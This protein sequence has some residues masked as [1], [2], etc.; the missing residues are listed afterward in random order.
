MDIGGLKMGK[1]MTK[2]NPTK[3]IVLFTIPMLLGNIFQQLYSMA[4][5]LIVSQTIG[6]DALAAVGSTGSITFLV[7]GLAIG[8]TAGLAVITAQRFG[9]KDEAGIRK[10]LAASVIISLVMS[11]ILTAVSVPLTRQILQWMQTPAEIIDYAYD[12]LVV[13]FAGI[14][15]SVAF[16]LLS[17]VLRAVGDSKTPLY[18]LIITSILNVVMDYVFIL[19]FDMGVA[20]AGYATV[21]SQVVASVLCLVYIGKKIPMLRIRKED[22]QAVGQETAL[23]LKIAL[24]MGFQYSIIAIG[25]IVLQVAL[26]RL[27]ADSIAAYTAAG[28]IDGIATLPLQSFGVTMATYAAQNYGAKQYD[29]IWEGVSKVN[30]IVIGYSLAAGLVLSLWGDTFSKLFVGSGSTEV[31]GMTRTYFLTNATMYVLLALL[32]IYRYTL[33]GLGNSLAP[34]VAGVMELICRVIG[35]LVLSN[36]F[37][38]GGASVSNPLAWLGALIPLFMAYYPLKRDL[39]GK[40]NATARIPQGEETS[41]D[42]V[43]AHTTAE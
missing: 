23:H 19:F 31:L 29:R 36:L 39:S 6:V 41:F 33:Q 1:D 9:E 38:F 21:L 24:P 26:N 14:G 12:Y 17:N 27:G 30:K 5:T 25:S 15:A 43:P 32:F 40:K 37:G 28:K 8:L 2:G 13:I 7:L 35:A 22:W 11:V 16:N 10:N 34:T 4:D 42:G 20:G 18:F 3:L